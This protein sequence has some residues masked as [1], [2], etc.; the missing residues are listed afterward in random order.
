MPG[1]PWQLFRDSFAFRRWDRRS[2]PS[3]ILLEKEDHRNRRIMHV[4]LPV[5]L[6]LST[7]EGLAGTV[8]R[9]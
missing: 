1:S 8:F 9:W 5:G 6:L 3:I 4:T 7:F 2:D